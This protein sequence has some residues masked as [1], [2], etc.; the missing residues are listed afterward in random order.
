MEEQ[1]DLAANQDLR[2]NVDKHLPD[3]MRCS[4][5]QWCAI[6]RRLKERQSVQERDRFALTG[7]F[8]D[9]N[10]GNPTRSQMDFHDHRIPD[11]VTTTQHSD[12]DSVIGIVKNAF[13]IAHGVVLKYFMLLS[14][15][16]TLD[17]NLHLPPILVQDEHG[18]NKVS[19]SGL[20]QSH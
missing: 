2:K 8:S 19:A 13:P 5:T 3:P 14:P 1:A 10:S 9:P 7:G 6:W 18:P 11:H 16:H 4:L 15:S 12:I 20:S 17:S